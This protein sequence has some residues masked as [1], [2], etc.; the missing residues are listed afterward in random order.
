MADPLFQPGDRLRY[1]RIAQ[2]D[3]IRG[4][5]ERAMLDDG[6]EDSPGFQIG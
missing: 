5:A 1:G 6:G 2:P 4:A 3:R